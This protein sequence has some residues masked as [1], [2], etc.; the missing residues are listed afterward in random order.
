MRMVKATHKYL[1]FLYK[2]GL[3]RIAY[4]YPSPIKLG[5]VIRF[6]LAKEM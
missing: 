2:L 5:M 3:G 6:A 4:L 1:G